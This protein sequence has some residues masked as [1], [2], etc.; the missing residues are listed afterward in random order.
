MLIDANETFRRLTSQHLI[1]VFVVLIQSDNFCQL[2]YYKKSLK[3]IGV[4]SF[5]L[6]VAR[7]AELGKNYT[8]KKC[9]N[10]QYGKKVQEKAGGVNFPLVKY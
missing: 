1:F 5:S 8:A 6:L 9:R 4:A 3:L 7:R 10:T 2:I